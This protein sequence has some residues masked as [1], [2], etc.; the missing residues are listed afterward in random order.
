MTICIR[1]NKIAQ[2]IIIII[3]CDT[4]TAARKQDKKKLL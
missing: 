3:L 1:N 2:N 4:H